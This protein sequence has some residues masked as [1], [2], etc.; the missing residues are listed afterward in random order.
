MYKDFTAL[1]AVLD[2]R[3]VLTLTM[4]NPPMNAMT[5]AMHAELARIFEEV[6]HDPEV[7][8]IVITGAGDKAFSAGGD[9]KAMAERRATMNHNSWML[10]ITEARRI[11][12]GML[13]LERPLIARVNGH[14]M[15]LGA[16]LAVYA[17]ITIMLENAKIADTH[18]KVGLT[19][20]DGGALLWPLLMGF[21]KA[22][23]YLLTGD[24][25]TG[26]QAAEYGLI[27]T[28]VPDIA[29]LD[30]EV[31]AIVNGMASGATQAINGT[32]RAI[33][34]VLRKLVEGVIEEHLGGET[35]TFLSEDHLEAAEAF[36]DKRTPEFKGR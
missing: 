30:A 31:D 4:D 33:N 21:A 14:A 13:R 15:G 35:V 20:G 2:G 34:L 5:R 9:I 29:A 17:D 1:N 23:R 36:R 6:N 11:I 22:R 25:M 3:G 16:T 10:G 32:K 28:A 7:K 8:V 27:S 18:V 12:Y 19:A 24:T 26:A